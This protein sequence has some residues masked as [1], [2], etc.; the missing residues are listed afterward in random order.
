M[1]SLTIKIL[2]LGYIVM[3]C[4]FPFFRLAVSCS[5]GVW[6]HFNFFLFPLKNYRGEDT[7]IRRKE[8]PYPVLTEL[9]GALLWP[10]LLFPQ[11]LLASVL[12]PFKILKLARARNFRR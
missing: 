9:F 7:E 4:A 6:R 2:I 11:I 12:A 3:V 10:F 5:E 8:G 1:E